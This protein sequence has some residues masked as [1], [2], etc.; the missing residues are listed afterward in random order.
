MV[1]LLKYNFRS[2]KPVQ[3]YRSKYS[4]SIGKYGLEWTG[5]VDVALEIRSQRSIFRFI[6]ATKYIPFQHLYEY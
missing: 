3:T 4:M 5:E 2:N 1:R 6:F